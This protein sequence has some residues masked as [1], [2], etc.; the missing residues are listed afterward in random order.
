MK[1]HI[2]LL[3][4]L[5]A[6]LTSNAQTINE[7]NFIGECFFIRNDSST[8]LL[9]K[10][11]STL[12]SSGTTSLYLTGFGSVKEKIQLEGCCSTLILPREDKIQFIVKAVDNS[13]DPLT[14][15][16]IIKFETNKK[17]ELQHKVLQIILGQ[18]IK[19]N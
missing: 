19:I 10:E 8:T 5:L 4:G 18:L 12:R 11:I 6:L 16:K 7:P 13:S 2:F 14:I 1:K 15:V 9:P 17:E 3:I